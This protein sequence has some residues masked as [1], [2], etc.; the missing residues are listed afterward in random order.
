[1]LRE[2]DRRL[3]RV[4]VAGGHFGAPP[5]AAV[6]ELRQREPPRLPHREHQL[7]G[8]RAG[9]P[10]RALHSL[11][12]LPWDMGTA[13]QAGPLTGCQAAAPRRRSASST[14]A[15]AGFLP[16]VIAATSRFVELCGGFTS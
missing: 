13:T 1:H 4:G 15:R 10:A 2:A 7:S 5:V 16:L 8:K 12:R 14:R 6:C 9:F 11:R 3:D